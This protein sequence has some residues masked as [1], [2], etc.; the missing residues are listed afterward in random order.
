MR[1][2]KGFGVEFGL[3]NMLVRYIQICMGASECLL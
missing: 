3:C 1:F 2:T